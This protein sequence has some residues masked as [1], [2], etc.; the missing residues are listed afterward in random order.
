MGQLPWRYR[1]LLL[2]SQLKALVLP[3]ARLREAAFSN[4]AREEQDKALSLARNIVNQQRAALE[5]VWDSLG[6]R[7]K[8]EMIFSLELQ[9]L[10]GIFYKV[11]ANGPAFPTNGFDRLVMHIIYFLVAERRKTF[12]EARD[13]ALSIQDLYNADDPVFEA[14]QGMGQVAYERAIDGRGG[15][16]YYATIVRSTLESGV[17]ASAFEGQA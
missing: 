16:Q 8:E 13:L 6:Y 2:K 5:S 12:D 9:F 4:A 10:W 1:W 3:S 7:F 17:S 11:V 14:I 15:D